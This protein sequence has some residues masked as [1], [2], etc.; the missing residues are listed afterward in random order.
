[1]GDSV[2]GSAAVEP[3]SEVG[4]VGGGFSGADSVLVGVPSEVPVEGVVCGGTF[5]LTPPL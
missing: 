2:V 4:D 5:F 1:M 3:E